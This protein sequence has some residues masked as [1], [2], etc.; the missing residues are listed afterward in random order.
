MPF[1]LASTGAFIGRPNGRDFR[2]IEKYAPQIRCDGFELM[3]YEDWYS[4]TDELRFFLKGLAV[5]LPT[6][7]CDKL[8]GELLA[9]ER[10]EEAYSRFEENCR[11]AAEIGSKLLVLH[12][13][14]GP[15]SDANIDANISG[16]ERLLWI[17]AQYGLTA[18]VENVIANG[19]SP[20]RHWHSL[21]KR[22]PG[23]A[24]TYD[25]KM[26]QF[27]LDNEK[28]F[29]PDNISLWRRVKHIHLNDRIG[30]YRDWSSY[31]ALNL[32][33]GDV[34]FETF[35]EGLAK[36]G[37]SGGFTVEASAFLPGGGLDFDGLISSL[38]RA[39]ELIKRHITAVK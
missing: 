14:N 38:D 6:F 18:T 32:G 30:G 20:L 28:A 35:F 21:A 36:V 5:E 26:A 13:W 37:Y 25:T 11:A 4:C 15:T 1:L 2:L 29:L 27:D 19:G 9:Q 3:F 8:I 24:F 16:Y 12:L 31:R 7:H 23:A 33:R 39:R 34:D 17:A 10:F 22:Y